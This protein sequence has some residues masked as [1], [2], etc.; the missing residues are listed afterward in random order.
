MNFQANTKQDLLIQLDVLIEQYQKVIQNNSLEILNIRIENKWSIYQNID[1]INR[2]NKMT[3]IGYKTPKMMLGVLFGK[4]KTGSRTTQEVIQMYQDHLHKGAKSRYLFEAKDWI[5]NSNSELLE[6]YNDQISSLRKIIEDWSEK[7][8][9]IYCMKHPILGNITAQEML[10]FT[11]YHQFHH[12]KTIQRIVE[13][14]ELM[15][16]KMS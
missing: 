12:M 10:S 9:N 6:K 11:V 4:S 1:H 3:T 8:L 7:D 15:G 16:R 13:N 2:S 14:S 5:I